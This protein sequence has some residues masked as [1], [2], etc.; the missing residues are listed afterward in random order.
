MGSKK[1]SKKSRKKKWKKELKKSYSRKAH[2][3]NKIYQNK[4]KDFL[5]NL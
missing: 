4:T 5:E 1:G 2:K 3:R